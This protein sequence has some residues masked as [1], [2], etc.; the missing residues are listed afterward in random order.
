MG[1]LKRGGFRVEEGSKVLR[2]FPERKREALVRSETKTRENDKRRDRYPALLISTGN[3]VL[4]HVP[5][6]NVHV[7]AV[8]SG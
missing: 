3:T 2:D 5:S 4:P 7:S 8:I 6:Y 1:R